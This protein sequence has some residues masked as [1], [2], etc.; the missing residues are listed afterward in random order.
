GPFH[1]PIIANIAEQEIPAVVPPQRP[2]SRS[3]VIAKTAG[4]FF[5]LLSWR[6]DTCQGRMLLF[7]GHTLLLVT[8]LWVV[9]TQL[10]SGRERTVYSI[11]TT[12][13]A[14]CGSLILSSPY[15]LS[16][17]SLGKGPV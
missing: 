11:C 13:R 4:Q 7:D 5:H 3:H 15:N 14:S 8:A 12:F 9:K 2:F 16:T 1:S 6:H 10:E 17:P